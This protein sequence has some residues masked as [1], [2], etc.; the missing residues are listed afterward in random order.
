MMNGSSVPVPARQV[1]RQIEWSRANARTMDARGLLGHVVRAV[2]HDIVAGRLSP[3]QT[4][5][6]EADWGEQLAVSRT[7]LREATKILIAKGLVESRPRTG[8]RVRGAEHWNVLDPDVL[9]WQ[10]DAAPQRRFVRELF[11]LRRLVEPAVVTIAAERATGGDLTLLE[12]AFRDMEAA[13]DDAGAFLDADARFHRGILEAVD[14]RLMRS[15]GTITETALMLSLR[16]SLPAPRGLSPSV[17]QHGAVLDAIRRHDPD[18]ARDAMRRLIEDAERDV[19]LA[20]DAADT[21]Q[22]D[23][24]A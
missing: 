19:V 5:P 1:E 24:V 9:A 13:G 20:L 10:L 21:P 16:L 14:N 6:N 18:A 15:L 4:L 7:V 3:G 12:G 22:E 8:T 23:Q 17:P 2:G 11:E